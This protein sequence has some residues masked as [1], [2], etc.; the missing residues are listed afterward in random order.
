VTG[1]PDRALAGKVAV[2]TGAG[3]GI[4]RAT[5][6]RLAE[7][8]ASIAAVDVDAAGA[9]AA[10]SDARERGGDGIAIAL[11]LASADAAGEI[12]ERTLDALGRLDV[13]VNNA[14]TGTQGEQFPDIAA[15]TFDRVI[16]VNLRAP[17]LLAQAAARRMIEQGDGGKIVN[18]TSAAGFRATM[19]NPVY[20]ASKAG[21]DALTRSLAAALGPYDINVNA[22]APG[23]TSSAMGRVLGD[24]A[25]LQAAVEDGP[26][27][28]LLRRVSTPDD[29][30]QVIA[31]LCTPAARQLTGQTIH[32]SAGN[33]V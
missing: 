2:V 17:Y 30:A 6:H 4:G 16:A 32:T 21:L 33:V 13:L 15:A 7:L 31:W 3:G 14:G 25:A 24:D 8:G 26:L 12:V 5:V 9:D 29:V 18:V 19:T 22:V 28:N 10:V 20:A 1:P 11:D 27:A 23:L